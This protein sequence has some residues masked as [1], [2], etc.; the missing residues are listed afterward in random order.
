MYYSVLRNVKYRKK[1]LNVYKR[2]WFLKLILKN[3][4]FLY[5]IYKYNKL[6]NTDYSI[7]RIRNKCIITGRSKAVFSKIKLS[8]FALKEYGLNGR[9][10]GITKY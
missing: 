7:C 6:K 2:K 4:F 3:H 10:T 5:D 9:L 1:H 8:R